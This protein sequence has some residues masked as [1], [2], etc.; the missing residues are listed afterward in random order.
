MKKT[1]GITGILLLAAGVLTGCASANVDAVPPVEPEKHD[2]PVTKDCVAGFEGLWN[3]TP[4]DGN[5]HG[6]PQQTVTVLTDSGKIIEAHDRKLDKAGK[7]EDLGITYTVKQDK[8]W[9][10]KSVLV[11]DTSNDKILETFPVP[12]DMPI[13]E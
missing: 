12:T 2:Q 4:V 8:S 1:L 3:S 10:K 11:I 6:L 9:P 7:P 13:C 5:T